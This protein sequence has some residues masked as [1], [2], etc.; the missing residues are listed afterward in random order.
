MSIKFQL[1]RGYGIFSD[2]IAWFGG[3]ALRGFSHVD[4]VM[5]D[6][7]LLGAR[8][9]A[10]GGRPPGVWSRPPGYERL[11]RWV[12]FELPATPEQERAFWAFAYSKIGQQYNELG[13]AG[14]A[15]GEEWTQINAMFCSQL[16]AAATEAAGICEKLYFPESEVTPDCWAFVLSALGAVVISDESE[17]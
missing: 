12:R 3:A 5:H 13:I 17:V 10:I 11:R 4:L 6:G 9:D 7:Q 1:T 15:L 16:A 2:L 8:D 14:F